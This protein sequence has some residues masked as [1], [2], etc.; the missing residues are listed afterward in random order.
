ME[1]RPEPMLR[2]SMGIMKGESRPGPLVIKIPCCSAIVCRPPM[3][4]PRKTPTS[5]RLTLFKSNP[6]SSSAL[7]AGKDGELPEAIRAPGISLGEGKAGVGSKSGISAAMRVVK[8][9]RQMK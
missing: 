6:L 7:V 1:K 4:E 2:M 9:R 5:S 3:P 8:A